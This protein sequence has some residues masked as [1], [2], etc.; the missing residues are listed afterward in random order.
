MIKIWD[1]TKGYCVRTIF[2]QSS[3]NSLVLSPD[4]RMIISGHFDHRLRIWDIKNGDCIEELTNL[5]SGQITSVTL[6]PDGRSIL[7]NS[8]DNTLKL[9]DLI[10]YKI[11]Q[12]YKHDLYKSGV[13]WNSACFSP[14]GQFVASGSMDGSIQIWNTQTAKYCCSLSSNKKDMVTGCSWH[15]IGSQLVSTDK[16]GIITIWS[17]SNSLPFM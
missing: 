6:S 10:T 9:V 11:V 16:A 17:N 12:T 2:C 7:T 14:D 13:N 8:R 15:P 1:M 4:N 3:C 5:H